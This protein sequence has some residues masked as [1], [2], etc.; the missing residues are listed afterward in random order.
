MGW[1]LTLMWYVFL[2]F[3]TLLHIHTKACGHMETIIRFMN[4][5]G[6]W[7]MQP[8]IVEWFAYSSKVA[9][10]LLEVGTLLWLTCTVATP[11]WGKCEDETRTPKSGNL[12]SSG[13]PET[14]KLDFR[15]QNTSPWGILYTVGKVLK[16]KCQ[17]WPCMSHSNI[18]S[19]GYCRKKG[20][21]SN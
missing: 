18:Y 6:A 8:M 10:V 15:S 4:I 1:M 17:K 21:E 3:Q 19:I 14:P 11:L 20:Q 5:K 13:T 2:T 16:S 9:D 7:C 12:E